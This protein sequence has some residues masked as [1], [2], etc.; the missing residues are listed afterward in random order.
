MIYLFKNDK[1]I[2]SK[3]AL[4]QKTPLKWVLFL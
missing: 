2:L 3:L 4:S 1:N